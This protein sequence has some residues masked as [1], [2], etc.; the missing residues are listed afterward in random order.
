MNP[1]RRWGG[2][3]LTV[4]GG[5]A[6]S[7]AGAGAS[8]M[9]S[10]MAQ[11]RTE[12]PEFNSKW[13]VNVMPMQDYETRNVRTA[14]LVLL[15]A[16]AFVLLIR[17]RQCREPDA[18]PRQRAGTRDRR[19][20][21][22]RPGRWDIVRQLMLESMM[23]AGGRRLARPA[24]L[25][26]ADQRAGRPDTGEPPTA[27]LRTHDARRPGSAVH[28]GSGTADGTSLG[29][30]PAIRASRMDLYDSLKGA[31]VAGGSMRRTYCAPRW[32]SPRWPCRSCCSRV[33][34]CWAAVSC[35]SWR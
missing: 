28:A 29:L 10:I 15:G 13:G 20:S 14:L 2:R 12:H 5:E 21:F 24:P 27:E 33:R 11:L 6:G 23:L 17:V 31:R 4:I 19:T 18:R 26:V 7:V 1:R 3:S 32:L 30:A 8:E 25:F 16:V 35:N 34:D 22:D 9:D